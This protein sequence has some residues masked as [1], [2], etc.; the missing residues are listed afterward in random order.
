MMDTD[1]NG[2]LCFEELKQGL[3]KLGHALPDSDV[4][5]ILDAVRFTSKTLYIQYV[6]FSQKL[7][8]ISEIY[9]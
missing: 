7:P 3:L 2:S 8:I 5:M 9:K 6:L 1:K 4:Q